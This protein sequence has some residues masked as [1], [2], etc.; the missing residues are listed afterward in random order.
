EI[1]S[2]SLNFSYATVI[3]GMVTAAIAG[4]IALKWMFKIISNGKLWM[5]S[6]YVGLLG[7]LVVLDQYIFHLVF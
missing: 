4:V 2:A 1:G 7:L 6:I 5:F 3:V